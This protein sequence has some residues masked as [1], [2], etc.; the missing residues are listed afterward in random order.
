VKLNHLTSVQLHPGKFLL[1]PHTVPS[2]TSTLSNTSMPTF[3]AETALASNHS[4][5]KPRL[6]A[7]SSYNMQPGDTVYL[8]RRLDTAT[9]IAQHFHVAITDLLAVNAISPKLNLAQGRKIIIPT[10]QIQP[11]NQYR[12]APG[13]TVYRVRNGETI[14]AIAVKFHTSVPAIRVANLLADNRINTGDAILIPTHA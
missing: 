6:L 12:V 5:L 2:L 7:S 3:T 11:E 10:H 14:D 8:T 1:V 9:R 13:D 4:K